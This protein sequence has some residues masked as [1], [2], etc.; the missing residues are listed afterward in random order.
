MNPTNAELPTV[1]DSQQMGEGNEYPQ[2]RAA[3]SFSVF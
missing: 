1:P 2:P 3:S